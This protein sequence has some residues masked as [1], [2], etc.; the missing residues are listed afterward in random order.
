M[1]WIN[2]TTQSQFQRKNNVS[3]DYLYNKAKKERSGVIKIQD[4]YAWILAIFSYV[5]DN[6]MS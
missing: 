4:K 3:T 1:N 6:Y 2:I 5:Q